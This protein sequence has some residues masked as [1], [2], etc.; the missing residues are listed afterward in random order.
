MAGAVVSTK[1]LRF[2]PFCLQFNF[3]GNVG[4]VAQYLDLSN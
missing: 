3:A 4:L 1:K 2:P